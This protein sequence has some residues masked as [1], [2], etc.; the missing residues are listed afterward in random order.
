VE[1]GIAS[2]AKY[3]CR[4][5]VDHPL[6]GR[7]SRLMDSIRVER[8]GKRY[9]LAR[10]TA[11]P[12]RHRFASALRIGRAV[13]PDGRGPQ[14][15]W[16][17]K[18]VSFAVQPGTVLGII[19]PNGAGKTTL[20][21]VL[22][23][24]TLP[25]EGRVVGRG[26]VISLL[27]VGAGF[28]P[29]L[30]G[31]ENVFLNA[32]LYGI[33]RGEVERRFDDIVEWAELS[34]FIDAPVKTYSTGMHLRLAFSAAVNM[35]P[36]ILLAD[37]ILAVGDL[38]FQE[39]CLQ[40]V[41][42]AGAAGQTVLFVSH[43]MAAINRLCHRVIWLNAGRVVEDGTPKEV[44]SRYEDSAWIVVADGT[45]GAIDG[46]Q[47][48]AYGE[49]LS[50]RLL[51]GE[52]KEVGAV[53]TTHEVFIKVIFRVFKAEADA[54]CMLDIH[55]NGLLVF[56]SQQPQ[57]VNISRPGVYSATVRIPAHLLSGAVYSAKAKVVFVGATPRRHL[58]GETV[59]FR[60]YDLDDGLSVPGRAR[61]RR[62]G[63]VAPRLEWQAA[64]EQENGRS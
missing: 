3:C 64:S 49:I 11:Q 30:S 19:G 27:E 41:E 42:K 29:E 14:E 44:V 25:T 52:G 63:I 45:N 47:P 16:A 57:P 38:S 53:R 37:E 6:A 20:L 1:P 62:A 32:A 4:A 43:D 2:V 28:Q 8:L 10:R 51:S 22:G 56:R 9:R 5:I 48:G 15:I 34:D 61:R 36:D 50:T 35:E 39:R 59:T 17:L 58:V 31:R 12:W 46:K 40:R 26:R 21:K 54:R 24:V 13:E 33:P 55:T 18:E 60:V 23:R 7:E